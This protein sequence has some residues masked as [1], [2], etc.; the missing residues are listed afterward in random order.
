MDSKEKKQLAKQRKETARQAQKF[1]KEQ[2]KQNKKSSA[3][4]DKADGSK[5]KIKEAV[6]ARRRKRRQERPEDLSREE[7]YLIEG[8]EKL[9]NLQP[10]DHDDGYFVDEY[11]EKQRQK[12]RAKQI[13]K[14][15]NEVIYRNKKPLSR[16]QIRIKRILISSAIFAAVLIIGVVLSLT[17]LFKTEKIEVEGDIYYDKDQIISFSNVAPQQNIF[18][19]SWNSTPEDIVNNLPYVEDAKISFSIPDTITIKVTNAVP[20]YAVKDGNAYLIVSSKG[21]ILETEGNK[22]EDLVELKCGEIKNKKK[23]E[24]I[25]LGDDSVYEI[26]HSV[27]KS[28]ADN[29]IDKVTGFDISSLSDITINYDNRIDI[30][31]G[32]PEDID[33]KIKT[34]F[35]IINEKLDPNKTGTVTGTLDVSTCNKNKI[36]HYKPN[37]TT[38]P[39]V[40]ATTAPVTTPDYGDTYDY[41]GDNYDYGG[42][43]YDNGTYD[44]GGYYDGGSTYDGGGYDNGGYYDNGTYDNGN[45]YDDGGTGYDYGG[46]QN[47]DW[48]PE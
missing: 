44:N 3:K 24:Y 6:I 30:N 11:A 31:I 19:G 26:L 10:Q 22:T 35:T 17:V 46:G 15:E 12:K 40:P 21:R 29:G 4:S 33:Y 18:I 14:Q 7:K 5:S 8:E 39:T 43:T 28:F 23:G 25:D 37:P 41:G 20:T 36:S 47:Y 48:Q 9:R 1:H 16:K 32:L 42:D 45:T 27:A 38:A 13:R 34:A 2:E